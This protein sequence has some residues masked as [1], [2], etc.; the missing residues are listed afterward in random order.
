MYAYGDITFDK[1]WGSSSVVRIGKK[2]EWVRWQYIFRF[3]EEKSDGCFMW[4]LPFVYSLTIFMDCI[5][6]NTRDI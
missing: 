5:I 2:R 4:W 1:R 6:L 3:G